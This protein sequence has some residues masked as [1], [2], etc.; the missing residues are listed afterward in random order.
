M[1]FVW[2]PCVVALQLCIQFVACQLKVKIFAQWN[3]IPSQA[4]VQQGT[5]PHELLNFP[6]TNG[7][8][9]FEYQIFLKVDPTMYY[10]IE[11][12]VKYTIQSGFGTSNNF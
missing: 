7:I 2:T 6:K 5:L 1:I 3:S 8:T 12:D 9:P 11:W 4:S 10:S